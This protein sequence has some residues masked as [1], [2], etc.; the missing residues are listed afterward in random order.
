MATETKDSISAPLKMLSIPP[1]GTLPGCYVNIHYIVSLYYTSLPSINVF[2]VFIELFTGKT[3]EL[4]YKDEESNM[5]AYNLF[6][7]ILTGV[8]SQEEPPKPIGGTI[9]VFK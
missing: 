2:K 1:R 8:P 5:K 9:R 3:I 7:N 6:H 4:E